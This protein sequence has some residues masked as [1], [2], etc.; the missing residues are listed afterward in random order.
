MAV[1]VAAGVATSARAE[2]PRPAPV[3]VGAVAENLEI[4]WGVTPVP[5]GMLVSERNSARVVLARDTGQ[6]TQVGVVPGVVPGGQGGL[7]G[8]AT[9]PDFGADR[10][11]YAFLTSEVDNR[12]VRMRYADGRLGA[13]E[14]VLLDIPKGP[15]HNGGRI[16]FGPDGMLYAG[17]GDATIADAPQDPNSLAGKILRMTPDGTV[18]ADNPF[19]GSLVYTLGHRNVQGFGWDS[20]GRM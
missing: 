12:I 2:E 18:P 13:P 17:T 6:V 16:H 15:S 10:Y 1:G 7:M 8:L 11:I 20:R 3:V 9:S 19:P 14:P 5:G 4:P